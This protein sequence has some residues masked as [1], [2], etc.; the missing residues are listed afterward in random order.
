MFNSWCALILTSVQLSIPLSA[1]CWN[2][3]SLTV[4]PSLYPKPPI[5]ALQVKLQTDNLHVC[6]A[7]LNGTTFTT[8]FF[9][10]SLKVCGG[11][12]QLAEQFLEAGSSCNKTGF[13]EHTCKL[14]A[15][16]ELCT[17]MGENLP[18]RETFTG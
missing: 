7:M 11:G 9:C 5:E 16:D 15:G 8:G 2:H 3:N 13:V 10:E 1:T 17:A 14:L 18:F 6:V 4:C 12:S